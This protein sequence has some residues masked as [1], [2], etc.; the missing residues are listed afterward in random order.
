MCPERV[1]QR[2][3][4]EGRDSRQIETVIECSKSGVTSLTVDVIDDGGLEL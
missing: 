1:F 2:K 3:D 4:R